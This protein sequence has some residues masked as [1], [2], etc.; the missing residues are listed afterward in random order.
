MAGWNNP[1]MRH[2]FSEL[3]L[4]KLLL[5]PALLLAFTVTALSDVDEQFFGGHEIGIFVSQLAFAYIGAYFFN[6][7]I[8]ER[9]RE[10]SLRGHY[11]AAWTDIVQLAK[12]P[13]AMS[14]FI[15]TVSGRESKSE[16]QAATQEELIVALEGM[17]WDALDREGLIDPVN[18]LMKWEESHREHYT[19]LIPFLGIFEPDVSV[20]IAH[21]NSAR[22]HGYLEQMQR[23][24]QWLT[25]RPYARLLS[26][27]L[28]DYQERGAQ[29]AEA[30]LSSQFTPPLPVANP[31]IV[32]RP[33]PRPPRSED[34]GG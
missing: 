18:N 9:P 25:A 12:T 10:R 5:W 20:A 17:D 27:R 34:D 14:S 26:G 7:L 4:P 30:L 2:W 24:R 16:N 6:W 13:S 28:V 3:R 32:F 29:L 15:L 23:D 22:I 33:R 1:P 31:H 21:M 8:V 11:D 19:A